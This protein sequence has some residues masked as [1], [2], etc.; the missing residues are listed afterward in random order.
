M[1]EFQNGYIT[2]FCSSKQRGFITYQEE[3]QATAYA[4][5]LLFIY[6]VH[7]NLRD[8]PVED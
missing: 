5:H 7:C 4:L 3:K 6:L 8:K 2:T 1:K